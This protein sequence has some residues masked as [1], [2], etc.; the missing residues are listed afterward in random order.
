M[1]SASTPA[2]LH[3][4]RESARDL[5][6]EFDAADGLAAYY[7]LYH[8][9]K[10]TALFVHRDAD[11]MVGG[12]LARCQT[13]FDLFRPL[14]T[15]RARRASA[16]PAL[17][18][19]GLLPGRPYLLVAPPALAESLAP[20]LDLT[21]TSHNVIYRLDPK[22]Y[23]H[24]VNVL[25]VSS[26][27]PEGHPRAEIRRGGEVAASAGVNWRSPIF[28]E[29]YASVGPEYQQRG[30]GSSVVNAVV[31]DLLVMGVTPLYSAGEDNAAS[32]ALAWSVGF[33]DSGAREVVA[34]AVHPTP[35]L[36]VPP[37]TP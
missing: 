11:G 36:P 28:A 26:R 32:Q 31:A 30:W 2:T 29:V 8:D 7:A 10:R 1:T 16:L 33:V 21:I 25:V 13:G 9:P 6:N 37:E 18:A 5:L 14:V 24:E 20:H 35:L 19:E 15:L 27:T 23:R 12:F 3:S 4:L 17:I 22:R 34:Q